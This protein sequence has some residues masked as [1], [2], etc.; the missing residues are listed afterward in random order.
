MVLEHSSGARDHYHQ[1]HCLPQTCTGTH[2]YTHPYNRFFPTPLKKLIKMTGWTFSFFFFFPWFIFVENIHMMIFAV[3]AFRDIRRQHYSKFL[4]HLINLFWFCFRF[5]VT[6]ETG[7]WSMSW[8]GNH[9]KTL[10]PPSR[11]ASTHNERTLAWVLVLD[12]WH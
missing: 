6:K 7:Y 5:C 10:V 8:D 2:T 9:I 11:L 12:C 4:K 1:A 3:F